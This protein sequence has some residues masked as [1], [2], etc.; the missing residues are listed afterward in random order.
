ML[1]DLL[2]SKDPYDFLVNSQ[3]KHFLEL[4]MSILEASIVIIYMQ[5]EENSELIRYY[6]LNDN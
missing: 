3:H 1:C 4:M 2:L 6:C 5:T